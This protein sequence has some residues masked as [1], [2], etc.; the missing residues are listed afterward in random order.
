MMNEEKMPLPVAKNKDV[1]GLMKDEIRG[2]ITRKVARTPPKTQG[3]RKQKGDHEIE[4]FQFIKAKRG[5][6]STFKE[7]TFH[8]F[9]TSIHYITNTPIKKE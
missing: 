3:Y 4:A 6:K 9:D 5:K 8:D 1:I 2:K 7:L